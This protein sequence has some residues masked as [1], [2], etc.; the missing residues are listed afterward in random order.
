MMMYLAKTPVYTI[1]MQGRWHSNAFLTYIE[2]QVLKFAKDVSKKMLTHNTFFNIPV[3]AWTETDAD[4]HSRS[5]NQYFGSAI[6]QAH[7]G[8]GLEKHDHRAIISF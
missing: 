5:A 1:M 2:K 4:D 8:F 6:R 3:R 7:N